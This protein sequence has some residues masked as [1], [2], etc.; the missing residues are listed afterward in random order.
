MTEVPGL[1][2]DRAGNTSARQ[3]VSR[4]CYS[5]SLRTARHVVRLFASF[6]A[7]IGVTQAALAADG[8]FRREGVELHYRT[9]GTGPPV[10]L[11][12]GG[13]G[14]NVED[15]VPAAALLPATFQRVYFEQ[16][17]TGRS[18]LTEPSSSNLTLRIV[19]DD[20]EALRVHLRLERLFLFGHSWG[21]MLAMAYAA[22]YPDRFSS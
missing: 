5:S 12:S 18:V 3:Q 7:V 11:L 22:A 13:P 19:V 10:V 14:L 21:G 15:L 6:I 9:D 2:S 17:G 4:L 8:T 20:L 1:E 16:R